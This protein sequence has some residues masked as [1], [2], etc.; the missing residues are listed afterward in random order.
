MKP[1]L[2]SVLLGLGIIFSPA[3]AQDPFL[4]ER[5][6]GGDP[7]SQNKLG[8]MYRRGDALPQDNQ[9]ALYWYTQAAEQGY[10]HSQYNLGQMYHQGRGVPKDDDMAAI[11]FCLAA[12]QGHAQAQKNLD[13]MG[14]PAC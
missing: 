1:I 3:M 9:A 5:A 13:R 11:W 10:S 6:Q 8:V 4:L 12:E 7:I 2:L 14:Q